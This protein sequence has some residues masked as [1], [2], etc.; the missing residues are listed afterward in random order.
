M[1]KKITERTSRLKLARNIQY[2]IVLSIAVSTM[3]ILIK[4]YF[5][6]HLSDNEF[7]MYSTVTLIMAGLSTIAINAGSSGIIICIFLLLSFSSGTAFLG[8]RIGD[9]IKIGDEGMRIV[10]VV[11]IIIYLILVYCCSEIT[12]VNEKQ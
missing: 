2:L 8:I 6:E 11:I 9:A 3:A 12:R 7:L 5:F 4:G 10:G 1:E